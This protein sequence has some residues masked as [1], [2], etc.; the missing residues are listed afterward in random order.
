[1]QIATA[2]AYGVLQR[3]LV[4]GTA[5]RDTVIRELIELRDDR[6]I[7][8]LCYV[9]DHTRPRG[10][11]AQVHADVIDALGGLSAHA[12]SIR[13]LR[14]VLYAGEWWAPLRTAAMRKASA[15]ALRRL[16]SREAAAILQEAATKGSRGV[17]NA[18]R[19]EAAAATRRERERA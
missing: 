5:T 12:D 11:L 16:G 8:V 2:D 13:T 3:A 14:R 18:A 19:I 7:P 6:A 17:R 9:L 10:R 15:S 4:A 1:V